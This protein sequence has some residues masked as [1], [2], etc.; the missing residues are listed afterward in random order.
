MAFVK[1]TEHNMHPGV[2]YDICMGESRYRKGQEDAG[3][4]LFAD[5]ILAVS[6]VEILTLL[7]CQY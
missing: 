1:I 4:S 2:N 5:P 6:G 3:N 7:A